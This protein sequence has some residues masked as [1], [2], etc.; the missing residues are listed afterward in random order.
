MYVRPYDHRGRWIVIG[1]TCGACSGAPPQH[2]ALAIA[3]GAAMG[4]GI[5]A[6]L[7]RMSGGS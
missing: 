7:N 6:W 1:G 2:M 5:G 4:M 3:L